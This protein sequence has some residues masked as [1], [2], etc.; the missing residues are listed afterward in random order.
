[1]RLVRVR[2]VNCQPRTIISATE[3]ISYPNSAVELQKLRLFFTLCGMAMDFE[4]QGSRH[5]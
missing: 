5:P 1:M 2:A 4:R 3:R